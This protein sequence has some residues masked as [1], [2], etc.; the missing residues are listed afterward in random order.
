MPPGQFKEGLAM[1]LANTQLAPSVLIQHPRSRSPWSTGRPAAPLDRAGRN[2]TARGNEPVECREVS[3]VPHARRVVPGCDLDDEPARPRLLGSMAERFGLCRILIIDDDH[4]A[5]KMLSRVLRH[6]G[7]TAVEV[8]HDPFEGIA[9]FGRQPPDLL[10]LDLHLP[11]CDGFQVL[12]R[13]KPLNSAEP[14]VPIVMLTGDS[15]SRNKRRA[16]ARGASDFL[17][18]PFNPME[19]LLRTRALLETCALQQQLS[20]QNRD[21]E[22]RVRERTA[23]LEGAQLEM[24]RRLAV[25]AELHDDDTGLHTQRVAIL[26]GRVAQVLGLPAARVELIVQAAPLHDLGKIG[27][28]SSIVQKRAA[29][30]EDEYEVMKTHALLG[31]RVLSG[32]RSEPILVA[33]RIARCHHERW[34]GTGY[35]ARIAG[36]SIPL[37]ARIVAVTDFFDALTHERPYRRALPVDHALEM[38][39]AGSG[40]HFD[41]RV[42]AA[43]ADVMA[44]GGVDAPAHAPAAAVRGSVS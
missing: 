28:P 44:D 7:L 5:A 36:E 17:L 38:V 15:D 22:A 10:F 1:N 29:L 30:S 43:L 41:P 42:A 16:L 26:A 27:I 24:L 9:E 3:G 2:P 23:A 25:A 20:A 33:E 12:D 14:A 32:G 21:L 19:V 39:R 37:E 8:R 31:A 40:S 18:K 4:G 6:A 34:D 13:L 35:P 11:G